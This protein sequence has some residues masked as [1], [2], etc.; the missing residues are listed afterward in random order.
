MTRK[1]NKDVDKTTGSNQQI[2]V[3]EKKQGPKSGLS[4]FLELTKEPDPD[5]DNINIV[6]MLNTVYFARAEDVT[7]DFWT[8]K[9]FSRTHG[10]ITQAEPIFIY[11][12][13]NIDNADKWG[14]HCNAYNDRYSDPPNERTW[15]EKGIAIYEHCDNNKHV[16]EEWIERLLDFRFSSDEGTHQF[17]EEWVNRAFLFGL[18]TQ[19]PMMIFGY[20]EPVNTENFCSQYW[21]KEN[22]YEPFLRFHE[23]PLALIWLI[24]SAKLGHPWAF[25]DRDPASEVCAEEADL[26]RLKKSAKAAKKARIKPFITNHGALQPTSSSSSS[27]N[28]IDSKDSKDSKDL[29]D[30][31]DS[32][33]SGDFDSDAEMKDAVEDKCLPWRAQMKEAAAV[34][35]HQQPIRGIL[36]KTRSQTRLQGAK[37]GNQPNEMKG[38]DVKMKDIDMDHED[39][40]DSSED[41]QQYGPPIT[42]V[43][44]LEQAESQQPVK[45][46]SKGRRNETTVEHS[47]TSSQTRLQGEKSGNQP[48]KMKGLD[49][50]MKDIDV[51][52]EDIADSSDDEHQYGPPIK[53]VTILEKAESQQPAKKRS[54]GLNTGKMAAL[55]T[56]QPATVSPYKFSTEPNAQ[57]PVAKVFQSPA[58]HR[59]LDSGW[60]PTDSTALG[61]P[62]APTK[63]SPPA[64]FVPTYKDAAN[65]PTSHVTDDQKAEAA[66]HPGLSNLPFSAVRYFNTSIPVSWAGTAAEGSGTTITQ[67]MICAVQAMVTE[68]ISSSDEDLTL[69]PLHSDTKPNLRKR[70][71]WISS[72]EDVT[73]KL[74]SLASIKRYLDMNFDNGAWYDSS[75]DRVRNRTLKARM[76]F[77]HKG[78]EE[79]MKTGI[80]SAF[81]EHNGG[82]YNTPLQHGAVL[83]IG[84]LA[85]CP[86]TVHKLQLAKQLMRLV[87][88]KY[89][90]AVDVGWPS[91]P[92]VERTWSGNDPQM[93]QVFVKTSEAVF[94]NSVLAS[95]ITVLTPKASCI[96]GS[97]LAYIPDFR[98]LDGAESDLIGRQLDLAAHFGVV[99]ATI[100]CPIKFPGMLA[101]AKTEHFGETSGLKVA[102]AIKCSPDLSETLAKHP[103]TAPEDTSAVNSQLSADWSKT[104]PSKGSLYKPRYM[105]DR[106]AAVLEQQVQK[107]LDYDEALLQP[108]S[109]FTV[110]APSAKPGYWLFSVR[111]KYESLAKR[112]LKDLP[113][114]L[115]FH[116]QERTV[117]AEDK[118]L[119]VW[120]DT[121]AVKASRNKGMVWNQDELRAT[122]EVSNTA[123][124]NL[125]S[126]LDYLFNFAHDTTEVAFNGKLEIDLEMAEIQDFDDGFTVAGMLADVRKMKESVVQLA[127][128][129]QQLG[130]ANDE[131]ARLQAQLAERNQVRGG[132][133]LPAMEDDED[134]DVNGDEQDNNQRAALMQADLT[135]DSGDGAPA[136]RP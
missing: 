53:S 28:S 124:M 82:C 11:W 47:K 86:T 63:K 37:R 19:C 127:A 1:K 44:I 105:S 87:G 94:I 51:D 56:H 131:I 123:N 9:C 38:L 93:V 34:K 48:N 133:K 132:A 81:K 85:Q 99:H 22:P 78:T 115:I 52:P 102:W 113:A 64:A 2:I 97:P 21:N 108:S 6:K 15:E 71:W 114:F 111:R 106:Q 57:K 49:V 60:G 75:P 59:L 89:P 13:D 104:S 65:L 54:K 67:K 45:K 4:S 83:R 126:G 130:N 116:L 18:A 35:G 12:D 29:D 122:S 31:K 128:T 40:A 74:N 24:T 91:K 16:L 92:G 68:A 100:E 61:P 90:I 33:D 80:H 95:K 62:N 39:I 119:R 66:L 79:H 134:E 135:A 55:T 136:V 36:T 125:H 5:D 26:Y 117:R 46:R 103:T 27:S 112:V 8:I 7:D 20:S 3:F 10:L 23:N 88:F 101:Q 69:L 25:P 42:S 110:I 30:S 17:D 121:G 72:A 58:S 50:K 120:L 76:R 129:R 70:K 118:I 73:T 84:S 14:N 98:A 96:W 32:K 43:T 41:E 77:G 107:M 109:L